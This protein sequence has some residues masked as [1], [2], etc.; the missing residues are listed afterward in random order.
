VGGGG[1][2]DDDDLCVCKG[3]MM[4]GGT[5]VCMCVCACVLSVV[6]DEVMGGDDGQ[7][8]RR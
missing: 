1:C 7:E 4:N 3:G 5:C 8:R 6:W 2:D